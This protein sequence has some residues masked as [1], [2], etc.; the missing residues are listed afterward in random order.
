M[1]AYKYHQI[2]V[3]NH[4]QSSNEVG[5]QAFLSKYEQIL[6]EKQTVKKKTTGP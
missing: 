4:L 1:H 2:P 6:W 3:C 5:A